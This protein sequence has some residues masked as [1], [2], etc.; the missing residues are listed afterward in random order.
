MTVVHSSHYRFCTV[1]C[2]FFTL[3]LV[4]FHCAIKPHSNNASSNLYLITLYFFPPSFHSL[5]P[6]VLC[7]ELLG[8]SDMLYVMVIHRDLSGQILFNSVNTLTNKKVY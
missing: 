7:E 4:S 6:C 8:T 1:F 5:F 2:F 3:L